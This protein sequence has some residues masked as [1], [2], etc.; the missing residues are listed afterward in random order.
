MCIIYE[1]ILVFINVF[2]IWGKIIVL[3]M[4]KKLGIF[5]IIFFKY[6]YE[7]WM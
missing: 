5:I 7:N 2:L 4:V 1:L 6:L 3:N